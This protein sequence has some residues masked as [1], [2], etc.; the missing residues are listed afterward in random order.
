M[1]KTIAL[2]AALS[3]LSL[4]LASAQAFDPAYGG[5]PAYGA[6][7]VAPQGF[8][9]RPAYLPSANPSWGGQQDEIGVDL[10]DRES[11]PYAGGTG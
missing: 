7:P 8:Q 9:S 2:V 6:V 11:S 4:N 1:W 10:R 3:S 5:Y